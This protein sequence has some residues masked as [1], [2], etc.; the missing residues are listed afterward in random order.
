MFYF[1]NILN[2]YLIHILNIY[3]FNNVDG[4]GRIIDLK[5][6]LRSEIKVLRKFELI[7]NSNL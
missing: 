1:Y 7:I 6:K 5:K 3:F 2:M 4:P